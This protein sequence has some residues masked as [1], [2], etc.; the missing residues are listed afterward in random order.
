MKRCQSIL[1]PLILLLAGC[2]HVNVQVIPADASIQIGEEVMPAPAVI[3]VHPFRPLKASISAKGCTP[4]ETEITYSTPENLEVVLKRQFMA[5]SIPPEADVL[6]DK[7][8]IGKTPCKIELPTNL[9]EAKLTFQK[10]GRFPQEIHIVPATADPTIH[11]E[12]VLD[13]PGFLF[14]D[15]KPTPY[16][17]AKV[18]SDTIRAQKSFDESGNRQPFSVVQLEGRQKQILSF[19]LLPSGDG[20]LASILVE[21]TEEPE[22]DEKK[23]EPEKDEKKK[24]P[25]K[26]E[27]KKG[28]V[29]Y[30]SQI[31]VIPASLN[32][33]LKIITKGNIDLTPTAQDSKQALFASNRTG[34]LDLWR[35]RLNIGASTPQKLDLLHSSEL[36]MMS[37]KI[38][39]KGN[40]VLVTVFQADKLN[41]PQIWS[42]TINDRKNILPEFFCN[43]E[44]P[45]WSPDGRHIV[46]QKD[47]PSA[48]WQIESDGSLI[49]QLSPKSDAFFKQP[50]WSP[51]GKHI[52]FVSNYNVPQNP[53]DTDIWIMDAD[54]G[55]LKPV[56]SSQAYD[57]MPVWA[58]DGKSIFF[59]S[60]R[61]FHWGIW[62]IQIP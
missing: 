6:L 50:A 11:V 1:L 62:N 24:E 44:N 60:N 17:K 56:T 10:K 26:D 33:P 43:G 34:R 49:K 19:S 20:I 23:K 46:F 54:G 8:L 29:K 2:H 48:I 39:P 30:E 57:D 15:I 35:C 42:F 18:V 37:P 47:S 52:A 22:K 25:E 3:T 58:P 32:Q 31:V 7:T 12:L 53:E 41:S 40:N 59:R 51:D 27:K 14:W 13:Q 45:D 38:Q 5:T 9:P 16:G 21:A 61:N 28:P 55:N 4:L 36:I